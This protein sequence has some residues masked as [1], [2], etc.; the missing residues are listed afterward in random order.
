M[1]QPG[2]IQEQLLQYLQITP[3]EI[4]HEQEGRT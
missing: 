1:L 3:D 2:P 4:E